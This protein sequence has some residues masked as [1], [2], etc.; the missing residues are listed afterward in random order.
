MQIPRPLAVAVVSLLAF[1]ARAEEPRPPLPRW[2]PSIEAGL[3]DAKARG[4]AF[5]V[6]LNMDNEA[7]NQRMLDEVYT[8]EEFRAASQKCVVA[9]AS[10]F[11]HRLLPD[12]KSGARVCERFGS[13]TCEQHRAIEDVVRRQWLGRGP[14][15]DVESP[16]H[17]FVAPNGKILF[18]RVWTIEKEDLAALMLRASELCTPERLE[19]WDTLEGRLE[20]AIDPIAS[21][22]EI[23]LGELIASDDPAVDGKLKET[24]KSV[25]DPRIVGSVLAAF[26]AAGT[27]ERRAIAHDGLTHKDPVVRTMVIH[28]MGR[29]GAADHLPLLLAR[30]GKEKETAPRASL[31]RALGVLG[32]DDEAAAKAVRKG[33]GDSDETARAN[34]F[35][36]AAPWAAEK[37]VKSAARK[38]LVEGG[39]QEIR[40]IAVWLLGLSGD[41]GLVKTLEEYKSSIG[42]W[43]WKL[44]RAVD[45]AIAKLSGK[46]VPNYETYAAWLVQDPALSIAR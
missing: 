10:L 43:D 37:A 17:I 30:A 28:A 31:Y 5:M 21:V 27:P 6:A 40:G 26:A 20:R 33:L 35:A 45:A 24:L 42:R 1:A 11:Q 25:K 4:Q 18:Q 39:S 8:S 3:A 9:V 29:S 32:K 2:A 36:A 15:D 34:A 16:R 14:K 22:R 46:D 41:A 12:A 44:T 23:A 13:V 38:V 7:G 19:R